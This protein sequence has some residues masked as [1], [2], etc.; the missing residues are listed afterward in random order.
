MAK[1]KQKQGINLI[2][3]IIAIIIIALIVI[4]IKNIITKNKNKEQT[5]NTTQTTTEEK[6]VQTLDNGTKLN[7]SEKLKEDKKVEELELKNIQLT[8]KNGV[9]N[10][11]CDIQNNSKKEVKM[12]DVEIVLLDENGDTIYKMRGFMEEIQPGETKQFNS[13]ITADFSNAY[14]FKINRK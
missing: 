3:L 10:L 1:R 6:Y 14:D 8:Y 5:N 9:T 12:E 13:S 2:T 7:T 11:L 4:F